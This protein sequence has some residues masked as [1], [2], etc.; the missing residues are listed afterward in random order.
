M[1][2]IV[3]LVA[4]VVATVGCSAADKRIE[5]A[6]V[7]D[8]ELACKAAIALGLTTK[9]VLLA[10]DG[11]EALAPFVSELID[12]RAHMEVSKARVAARLAGKK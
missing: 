6:V 9:E 3:A 8:G 7:T 11:V 12:A 1:K 10:C 2:K 4:F 5:H